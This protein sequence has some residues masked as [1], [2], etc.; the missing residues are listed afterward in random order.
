MVLEHKPEVSR[1]VADLLA[2]GTGAQGKYYD[3]RRRHKSSAIG[4]L[5]VGKLF[6]GSKTSVVDTIQKQELS[7]RVVTPQL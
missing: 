1:Q 6:R 5:N 4:A 7:R 2:H 3:R